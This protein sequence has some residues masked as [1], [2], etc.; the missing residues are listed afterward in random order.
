MVLCACASA[1]GSAAALAIMAWG[2][3]TNGLVA[4]PAP[5]LSCNAP[6]VTFDAGIPADWTV[7]DNE[8]GGVVWTDVKSSLEEGNYTGGK[9]DAASVSSDYFNDVNG[10]TEFDTELRTPAFSVA[11][12]ESASLQY[13]TNYQRVSGP[14]MDRDYLD[15]DIRAES[16]SDWTNLLHWQEDHGTFRSTPGVAVD[17]NLS[18]Y[19]TAGT[20]TARWHYY[21]PHKGDDDWYAQVDEVL[22]RCWVTAPWGDL[23]CD[24]A[25]NSV[26]ALKVLR[27]AAGLSVSHDEPC[28]EPAATVN[29]GGIAEKPMGDVDCDG[30][31][32]SVDALKVLRHRSGLPVA[33][34]QPCPAVGTSVDLYF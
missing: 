28:P 33:Q 9:N 31:I 12:H 16:G 20:L 32:N 30:I 8:G 17:V 19:T 14:P 23:D 22:L 11:G 1:V 24:D 2:S 21:D 5:T 3:G 7:V 6:A 18:A 15:V 26:D 29:A 10:Q 13:R 27:H 25:V 34:T 4:G